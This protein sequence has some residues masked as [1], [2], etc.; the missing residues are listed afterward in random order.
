M[1]R[2][3]AGM[4]SFG[5][6]RLNQINNSRRALDVPRESLTHRGHEEARVATKPRLMYGRPRP[7]P[8]NTDLT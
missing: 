2:V 1:Q 4:G 3:G 8:T 7:G 5:S 6:H